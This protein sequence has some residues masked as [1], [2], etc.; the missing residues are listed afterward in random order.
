MKVSR[1][2]LTRSAEKFLAGKSP[3]EVIDNGT[4]T[5]AVGDQ[6]G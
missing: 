5:S 6:L 1:I 2:D 4:S 3:Q